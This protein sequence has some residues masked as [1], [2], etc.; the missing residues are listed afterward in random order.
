MNRKPFIAACLAGLLV[1]VLAA[2]QVPGGMGVGRGRR[3]PGRMYNPDA[4]QTTAGTIQS[5]DRI[6]RMNHEIVRLTLQSKDETVLVLIGP[7]A[8]VDAQPVKL[9]VGDTIVVT[10]SKMNRRGQSM[11][12]AAEITKD[13]KTLKLRDS[14][15]GRPLWPRP[16]DGRR[17]GPAM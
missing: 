9:E 13:G 10:G 17:G 5:I 4:V 11:L 2:A 8:Y 14:A 3:G 7:A 12:V 16:R 15:T 6:R 1:T